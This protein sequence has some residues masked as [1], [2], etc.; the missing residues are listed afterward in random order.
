[1]LCRAQGCWGCCDVL[2]AWARGFVCDVNESMPVDG[3]TGR[4]AGYCGGGC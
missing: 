2:A 3:V 1:M 4:L